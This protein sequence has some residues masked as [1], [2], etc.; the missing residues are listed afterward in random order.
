MDINELNTKLVSELREIAKVLGITDVEKLR[1][2]ELID[3]IADIA[4]QSADEVKEEDKKRRSWC[5][6]YS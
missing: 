4:K 2:Q 6:A 5:R 3:Q 1:K